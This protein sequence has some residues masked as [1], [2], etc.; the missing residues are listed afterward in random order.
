MN[1]YKGLQQAYN[2][3]IRSMLPK[4][5][6]T[7]AGINVKDTPL[8]DLT[9]NN[10]TYKIGLILTI[11]DNIAPDDNVEIV[12]F[13]RGVTTTHI[14]Y[15]GA[16]H[17][18]GY[19]G[20]INMVKKGIDTVERNFGE[21]PPLDVHHAIVGDPIDIYGGSSE[22]TTVPP[23]ELSDADVLV[24]DCEGAEISIL[25]QLGEYPETVICESH[26]SKGAPAM[27]IIELL[28]DEYTVTTRY[29]KPKR[30]AKA[31]V[32]GDLNQQE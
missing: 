15:A 2:K 28:E 5:N 4:K 3:T 20:A 14:L 13:G 18:V 6:R 8:F 11:Y 30:D 23:S 17:V 1:I 10:P 22:A 12:G 19:E 32:V 16:S 9:A 26:P 25:S 21:S 31:I 7:L 27:E 29:H 24:L